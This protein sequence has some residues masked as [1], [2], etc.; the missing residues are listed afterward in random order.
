MRS[1]DLSRLIAYREIEENDVDKNAFDRLKKVIQYHQIDEVEKALAAYDSIV[2][3]AEDRYNQRISE[4][5][6]AL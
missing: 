3:R 1:R 5:L 4:M 2:G 6:G